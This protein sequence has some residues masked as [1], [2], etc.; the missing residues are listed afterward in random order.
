MRGIGLY[1][2]NP[3][4]IYAVF[5][6]NSNLIQVNIINC[7]EKIIIKVPAIILR[8]FEFMIIQPSY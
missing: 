7:K 3:N 2:K 1:K 5:V 6:R 8:I 4:E